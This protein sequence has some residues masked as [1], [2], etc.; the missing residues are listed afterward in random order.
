[1]VSL[2]QQRKQSSEAVSDKDNGEQASVNVQTA[3][4]F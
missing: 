1:M 4:Q 3:K 2:E